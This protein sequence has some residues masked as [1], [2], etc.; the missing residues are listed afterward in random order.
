VHLQRVPAGVLRSGT[1]PGRVNYPI[2]LLVF[3]RLEERSLPLGQHERVLTPPPHP[4]RALPNSAPS[5][6]ACGP[7]DPTQGT[8]P[9]LPDVKVPGHA[10]L[11]RSEIAL[12]ELTQE[13]HLKLNPKWGGGGKGGLEQGCP[14]WEA[15]EA[16]LGG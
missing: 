8:Y 11:R 6:T 5:T 13:N 4:C 7:G 12:L 14:K 3:P 15:K 9:K 16:G 10:Q 1:L 2:D